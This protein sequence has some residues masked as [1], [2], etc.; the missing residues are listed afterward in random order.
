METFVGKKGAYKMLGKEG[1]DENCLLEWVWVQFETTWTALF[2]IGALVAIGS[3]QVTSRDFNE[4][5][6]E[7][8]LFLDKM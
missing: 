6:A 7:L 3:F 8:N 4:D 5:F 2:R 1:E